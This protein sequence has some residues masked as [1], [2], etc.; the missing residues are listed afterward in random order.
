MA[1]E[2]PSSLFERIGGL[3]TVRRLV[4]RFYRRVL[5]DDVLAPYFE[6]TSMD[7]LEHM[8]IELFSAALG[9]PVRYTGRSLAE[10]HAG[11]GIQAHE[12]E[13]FLEHLFAALETI[14]ESDSDATMITEEDKR[15]VMARLERYIPEITS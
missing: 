2:T 12:L 1:Q 7:K 9:G 13:R 5:G 10:V 6:D 4:G 15:E 8:Q 11:R 14:K 3:D